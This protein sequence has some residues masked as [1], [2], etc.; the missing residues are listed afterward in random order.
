MHFS[1]DTLLRN[2]M[3]GTPILEDRAEMKAI[4]SLTTRNVKGLAGQANLSRNEHCPDLYP[5]LPLE[6]NKAA[7]TLSRFRPAQCFLNRRVGRTYFISI[8]RDT[9]T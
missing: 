4:A 7:G 2:G 6:Q 1:L 5:D 9:H 8:R 3:A